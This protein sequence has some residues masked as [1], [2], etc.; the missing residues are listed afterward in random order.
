MT[1][2]PST[3][4]DNVVRFKTNKFY[5][6]DLFTMVEV[7]SREEARALDDASGGI[8]FEPVSSPHAKL[9]IQGVKRRRLAAIT[10][11]AEAIGGVASAQVVAAISQQ[12]DALASDE[13]DFTDDD[14]ARELAESDPAD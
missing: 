10:E 4:G 11:Q 12:F 7:V 2:R 13:N 1:R 6:T 5:V 3:E 9:I 14:V 8:K